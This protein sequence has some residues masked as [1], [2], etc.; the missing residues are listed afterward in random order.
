MCWDASTL[1]CPPPAYMTTATMSTGPILIV[2]CLVS[3][4]AT[5]AVA[6]A[7]AAATATAAAAAA[8]AG[9][10]NAR[11]LIVAIEGEG[12]KPSFDALGRCDDTVQADGLCSA[13]HGSLGGGRRG[14]IVVF[15]C[16]QSRQKDEASINLN[17]RQQRS[18]WQAEEEMEKIGG[19]PG[20]SEAVMRGE[21]EGGA[22]MQHPVRADDKR[23]W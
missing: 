18:Q 10:I 22:M 13:C 4:L 17:S 21:A 19:G 14:G 7:A 15:A 6:A 11:S 3:A 8:A 20:G 2:C 5:A 9:V 12:S 23:Q 1:I 16:H